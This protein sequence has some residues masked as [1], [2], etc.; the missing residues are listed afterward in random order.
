MDE[1]QKRKDVKD[2][3]L[4]M[5]EMMKPETSLTDPKTLSLRYPKKW[6]D[7]IGIKSFLCAIET[8]SLQD[9]EHVSPYINWDRK[10]YW[11]ASASIPTTRVY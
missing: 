11:H 9:L 6:Q 8:S 1:Q 7:A 5:I 3:K 2:M 4:M 10:G